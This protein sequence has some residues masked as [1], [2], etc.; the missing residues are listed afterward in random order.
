MT[1]DH[2]EIFE[3]IFSSVYYFPELLNVLT[4]AQGC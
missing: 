4:D 2:G 1:P 3:W